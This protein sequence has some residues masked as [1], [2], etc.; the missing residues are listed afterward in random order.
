MKLNVKC[1]K[2]DYKPKDKL[3]DVP[4]WLYAEN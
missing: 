2:L 4:V 1:A 3:I